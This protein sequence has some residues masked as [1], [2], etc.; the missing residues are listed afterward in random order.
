LD[1]EIE[2]DEKC[3]YHF[4]TAKMTA[5]AMAMEWETAFKR[6]E[7]LEK[8]VSALEVRLE[9]PVRANQRNPPSF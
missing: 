5:G 8:I 1:Y 7:E 4:P 2:R 9:S 6:I 3:G